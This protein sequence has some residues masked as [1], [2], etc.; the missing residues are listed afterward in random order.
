[1]DLLEWPAH[2]GRHFY[3]YMDQFCDGALLSVVLPL[4][5]TLLV[6]L[7]VA[8]TCLRNKYLRHTDAMAPSRRPKQASH[9]PM[10]PSERP[11]LASDRPAHPAKRR[12]RDLMEV[13]R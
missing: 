4:M 12:V 5:L 6:L 13:V 11:A 3:T 10:S 7:T 1:M 9:R 2:V 8:S